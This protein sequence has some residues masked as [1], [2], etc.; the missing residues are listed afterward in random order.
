MCSD[1]TIFVALCQAAWGQAKAHGEGSL[2]QIHP[3]FFS[4]LYLA[5]NRV[6]VSRWSRPTC[7]IPILSSVRL[8]Q[9][10][11][12]I[13]DTFRSEQT[14]YLW[15]FMAG[16]VQRRTRPP[17]GGEVSLPSGEEFKHGLNN[18]GHIVSRLWMSDGSK[19]VAGIRGP[20]CYF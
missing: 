18:H 6:T 7:L 5:L 16:A 3:P 8:R 20:L 4:V 12:R 15:F 9:R 14:S 2:W 10:A 17:R 1:H 13:A 19:G 11:D